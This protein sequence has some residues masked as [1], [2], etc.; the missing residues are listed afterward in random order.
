MTD[1]GEVDEECL[2]EWLKETNFVTSVGDSMWEKIDVHIKSEDLTIEGHLLYLPGFPLDFFKVERRDTN[3]LRGEQNILVMTTE[4]DNLDLSGLSFDL[5]VVSPA[6]ASK[7]IMSHE[8]SNLSKQLSFNLIL[9]AWKKED[10]VSWER[11]FKETTQ[12]HNIKSYLPQIYF[13]AP[14]TLKSYCHK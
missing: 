8:G 1:E 4:V 10:K 11:H 9:I 12:A 5:A 6:Q 7:N 14:R 13:Y 2:T 3:E